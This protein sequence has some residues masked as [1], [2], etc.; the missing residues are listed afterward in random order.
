MSNINTINLD[1]KKYPVLA[2]RFE[3][4][5]TFSYGTGSDV[6]TSS[7]QSISNISKSTKVTKIANGGDNFSEYHLPNHIAYKDITLKRG[8]MKSFGEDYPLAIVDWF[9]NLG[10]DNSNNGR[11]I[12]PCTM[13]I[14]LKDTDKDNNIID[15]MMWTLYHVY[16][17]DVK[18]GEFHS[19]KSEVAIETIKLTYSN[20]ERQSLNQ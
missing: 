13:Q 10:W 6:Y 12:W 14:I 19:Q 16:P 11:R 8:I 3:V 20:Y 2:F 15:K 1:T 9:E 4:N 7:F 5:F 17:I 18:L